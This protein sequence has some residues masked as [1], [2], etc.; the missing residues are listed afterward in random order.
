MLNSLFKGRLGLALVLAMV[1]ALLIP[2]AALGEE[3]SPPKHKSERK[4]TVSCSTTTTTPD[5][6][7]TKD[8]CL[9]DAS[10]TDFSSTN[11]AMPSSDVDLTFPDEKSVNPTSSS[12]PTSDT[13]DT[14]LDGMM[15]DL[16]W[17][18]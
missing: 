14:W 15:N 6:K 1:V 2:A 5:G 9:T 8:D 11:T 12:S 13:F 3:T 16:F 18:A 17:A 10:G 4:Q 7:T